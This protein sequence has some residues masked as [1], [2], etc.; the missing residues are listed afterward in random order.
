MSLRR[1]LGGDIGGRAGRAEKS[2]KC[3]LQRYILHVS[4]RLLVCSG[5]LLSSS[6]LRTPMANDSVQFILKVILA[7]FFRPSAS[8]EFEGT[9]KT[10]SAS[11]GSLAGASM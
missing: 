11:F 2:L 6:P 7:L 9:P 4:S 1:L 3:R 5:S 10:I 8:L